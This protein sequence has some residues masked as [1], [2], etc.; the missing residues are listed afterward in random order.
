MKN[1]LITVLTFICLLLASCEKQNKNLSENELLKKKND[2]LS[3]KLEIAKEAIVILQDRNVWYDSEYDNADFKKKGIVD[4]EKFI[5]QE[6]AKRTD[7][8]PLQP[9]LG[10]KM[11]FGTIQLLGSKFLIAD[12]EDGH[13]E[14]KSLY[15][16]KLTD[17]GNLEFKLLE[18]DEN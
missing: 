7:L 3:R 9:T 13:V 4:P 16:Y 6:L 1:L 15:S 11:A 17:S 8:I 10:G 2:S 18:S 12:Y 14:G 5:K